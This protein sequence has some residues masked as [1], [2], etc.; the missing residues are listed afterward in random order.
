MSGGIEVCS[1]HLL[2]VHRTQPGGDPPPKTFTTL[3]DFLKDPT[4][5]QL[6]TNIALCPYDQ[7]WRVDESKKLILETFWIQWPFILVRSYNTQI[8]RL[9]SSD[10]LLSLIDSWRQQGDKSA[11]EGGIQSRI[12]QRVSATTQSCLNCHILGG[13]SIINIWWLLW[14]LPSLLRHVVTLETNFEGSRC[15]F[16]CIPIHITYARVNNRTNYSRSQTQFQSN[17]QFTMKSNN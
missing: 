12:F 13:C 11:T 14:P 15:D 10:D 3:S 6:L 8:R 9:T 16:Y 1:I 7:N 17:N 5:S 4:I 2:K